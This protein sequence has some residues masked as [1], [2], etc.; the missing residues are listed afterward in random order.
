MSEE[1]RSEKHTVNEESSIVLVKVSNWPRG[2]QC[3]NA[4]DGFRFLTSY[5]CPIL[6]MFFTPQREQEQLTDWKYMSVR[7][8]QIVLLESIVKTNVW[9]SLGFKGHRYSCAAVTHVSH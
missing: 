6:F 7:M 2:K 3:Q 1:V 5:A 9:V 4:A 8:I